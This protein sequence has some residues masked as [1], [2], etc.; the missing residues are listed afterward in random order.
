MTIVTV[1]SNGSQHR[2]VTPEAR[3]RIPLVLFSKVTGSTVQEGPPYA[4]MA[5]L[6]KAPRYERGDYRFDSYWVYHNTKNSLGQTDPA[7][8]GAA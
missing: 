7:R 5:K 3:V 8:A 2:P 6:D 1:S 4:P